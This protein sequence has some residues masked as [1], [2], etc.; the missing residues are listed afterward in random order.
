MVDKK[1]DIST[2]AGR[3]L[4]LINGGKLKTDT[5][6]GGVVIV[7]LIDG[8]AKDLNGTSYPL[9]TNSWYIYEEPKPKVKLYQFAYKYCG[10]WERS[11]GFYKDE[12]DFKKNNP[13]LSKSGLMRL[14]NS[15][16]E[17]DDE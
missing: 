14:D 12:D 6:Y 10:D 11:S 5:F 2:Q 7:S 1:L 4:H 3:W 9:S 17:V 13:N 15:M 16:I 8:S